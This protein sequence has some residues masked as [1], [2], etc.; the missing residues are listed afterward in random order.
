MYR[1][2]SIDGNL[3]VGVGATSSKID[4]PSNQQGFT[5][6]TEPHSQSPWISKLEFISTHPSPR[7]FIFLKVQSILNLTLTTKQIHCKSLVNGSDDRLKENEELIEHACETLSKLR[8]QLYDKKPDIDNDDPT[9]WYKES[10]LIAQEIYYDAPELRH[11]VHR[12]SPE[13]D[14][15]G[16]SIPLPE[17]PT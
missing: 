2:T 15:E 1:D 16:N 9:A 3:D 6:V 17:I 11:L 12:G 13:L 14:E 10:G 7:S 5:A 4:S 8:P